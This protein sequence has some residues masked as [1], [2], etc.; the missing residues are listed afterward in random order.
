VRVRAPANVF[1]HRAQLIFILAAL[2]PTIFMT[3]VGIVLLFLGPS[4][5][6]AVV[7]GVLVLAFCAS[8]LTGY[9]LG[10]IFVT[11]GAY[12][13]RIQNEFLAAVSH[14]LR[15]P[16]TSMRMFIDTLREDRVTEAAERRRC[17]DVIH[18]EMT[19]LDGLVGK[20]IELSKIES[21]RHAFER[22]R[23]A[24][25]DVVEQALVAFEAIRF[26]TSVELTVKVEPDLHVFGDRAALAQAIAN[27]L[28][29]ALKYTPDDDKRIE[30]TAGVEGKHIVITVTD[31]GPGI[32]REEQEL[33]FERF[34][35]GSAAQSTS[36]RKTGS[37]LGLAIV[38]A[39]LR[40]HRGRVELRPSPEGTGARFRIILPRPR[41]AA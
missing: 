8:S 18:R 37:G 19:R 35:R 32:P 4:R 13:A 15:T 5:N 21:G 29:N 9:I 7:A 6:V 41:E 17:L 22:K 25:A 16:L 31:N 11:R 23:V 2:I 34:E 40:A 33:I 20:L 1:L 36:G 39:I 14:E 38:R 12:L 28:V 27:L 10:T 26:G 30:L 3:V 24:V